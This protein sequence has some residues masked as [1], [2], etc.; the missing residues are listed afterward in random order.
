[1][2]RGDPASR[3]YDD[4]VGGPAEDRQVAH[5]PRFRFAT[6]EWSLVLAARDGHSQD[7]REALAEL[8]GLYWYPLYAYVRRQ[9]YGADEAED[10]T[11]G[12]F[13][14]LVDKG[15]LDAVS[16]EKGRFRSFLL[17]ACKHF[18]S[19]ERDRA[20]ALKRGGGQRHLSIDFSSAEVRYQQEPFHTLTPEAVF[21]RRWV[22]TLLER[23]LA[24]L[25]E[26]FRAAG[27]LRLWEGLQR[28]LEGDRRDGSY[29]ESA[30][31]LGMTPGAVKVA[32]HRLRRR[33]QQLLLAE[34][35]RT[36]ADP[37]DTEA[38]LRYLSKALAP[39]RRGLL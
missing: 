24:R 6:T 17:A 22:L 8:C 19:N 29:R 13:A 25:Q 35:G 28:F 34:V 32:V 2:N 39:T 11:Q 26:E 30:E 36:L 23:V 33:Y 12:F 37:T 1:V 31:A 4:R 9:G 15:F 27:K 18:L 5:R 14:R 10:L 3:S 20:R 7:A 16:P 38:E 21:E